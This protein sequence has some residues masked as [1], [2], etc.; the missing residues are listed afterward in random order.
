MRRLGRILYALGIHWPLPIFGFT[1]DLSCR[2]PVSVPFYQ[3]MCGHRKKLIDLPG[4]RQRPKEG[5][6]E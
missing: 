5:D 2:H 1:Q 6:N 3:C 4:A